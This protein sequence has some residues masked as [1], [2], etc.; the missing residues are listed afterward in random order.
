MREKPRRTETERPVMA[1]DHS[2]DDDWELGPWA[3]GGGLLW[4]QRFA[5]L[6]RRWW[7]KDAQPDVRPESEPEGKP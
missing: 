5:G 7:K 4:Q 2:A 1:D 3:D 6:F